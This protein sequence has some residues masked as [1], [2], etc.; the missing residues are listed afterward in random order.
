MK[1]IAVVGAG[2]AG[3]SAARELRTLGWGGRL[4]VAGGEKHLPYR[5]P[6][7][8]KE[9][10][11]EQV[12]LS[13]VD[14]HEVDA[15]W[16]RNHWATELD[17]G[18][19]RILFHSGATLAFDGVII[20]TGLRA[21]ALPPRLRHPLVHVLRTLDDAVR[22]RRRLASGDRA[23]VIGGGFI[24]SEVASALA[25]KGKHVTLVARRDL[26]LEHALGTPV[27]AQLAALHRRHGVDLRLGRHVTQLTSAGT[28]L[29][30]SLDN[31]DE[32]A[33]DFAIAALG[34]EPAVEW[35]AS[36]GLDVVGGVQLGADGLAAPGVAA[37]GDVARS[38][39]PLL[40]GE[41][42]RV[43]HYSNAV[44]QGVRAAR[45]VLGLDPGPPPLPSFWTQVHDW[46][47]QSVGFTGADLDVNVGTEDRSGRL[48]AE[49]RR[50][51]RL[52][53][54]VVEGSPRLL[55]HY[56]RELLHEENR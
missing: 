29:L 8:S 25:A 51:G 12:D 14:E 47:L 2:L 9:F 18:R 30:A 5:R 24:G 27:A 44:D 13:L 50:E 11:T 39:H 26:P 36:S 42:V 40:G 1:T 3:L 28:G 31:G 7:L 54:A 37:A 20:A 33:A 49:Y 16:W 19:R 34:S 15:E 22:L 46:R 6:P 35:L 55:H 4:V 21:R 48:V 10:L 23:L 32:V 52:V 56:R 38:P 43:E 45:A 41:L 53:G 17:P